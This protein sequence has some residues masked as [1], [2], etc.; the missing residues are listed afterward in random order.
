MELDS[1]VTVDVTIHT[2]DDF[3]DTL[4]SNLVIDANLSFEKIYLKYGM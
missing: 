4:S 2:S 3:N 1:S